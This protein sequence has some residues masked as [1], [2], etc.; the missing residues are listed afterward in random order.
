MNDNFNFYF[1]SKR[2]NF[3]DNTLQAPLLQN[4]DSILHNP[5]EA[6]DQR[7]ITIA[8][9]T[10]KNQKTRSCCCFHVTFFPE[11]E[12]TLC[13]H[14]IVKP[15]K[16]IIITIF[17]LAIYALIA[18]QIIVY[19]EHSSKRLY[20]WIDLGV[21][22]TVFL[23]L[24]VSYFSVMV[25]GPGYLPFNY[26]YTHK[27]DLNWQEIINTFAVYREQ[28]DFARQN[29]RPPR[30]SFS[31]T[32]RRFVL[33]ADHFC[34]WTESWIGLNNYRYFLLMTFYAFLFSLL[35][36]ISYH[37]WAVYIFIDNKDELKS[38]KFI[39]SIILPILVAIFLI[40]ILLMGAFYFLRGIRNLYKNITGIEHYKGVT[41][42]SPYDHGCLNNFSEVCGNKYCCIFWW[43]PLFC[44]K[45][46]VDGLYSDYQGHH[47][48][49]ND[50]Q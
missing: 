32:A 49:L 39:I 38:A 2:Q 37:W 9:L 29:E 16:P 10:P 4:Q 50:E 18:Y 45:P 12:M 33:R 7:S 3:M 41:D 23:F 20:A 24:T 13:N 48:V 34:L 6:F 42:N 43:I 1:H 44:F 17:F 15:I 26:S 31:V 21:I 22:S 14:W 25:R 35:S 47:E 46:S 19:S 27:K 36:I 28:V 40:I 30:S 5:Q 11:A 8:N